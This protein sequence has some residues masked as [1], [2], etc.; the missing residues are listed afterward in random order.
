MA[1]FIFVGCVM[2]WLTS[3]IFF[4]VFA[5]D[6]FLSSKVVDLVKKPFKSKKLIANIIG[7]IAFLVIGGILVSLFGFLAKVFGNIFNLNEDWI[8]DLE[9]IGNIAGFVVAVIVFRKIYKHI[10]KETVRV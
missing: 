5:K 1:L 10:T 3:R 6:K 2:F 8:L 7:G 4:Y 9:A